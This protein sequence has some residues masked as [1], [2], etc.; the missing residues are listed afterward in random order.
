MSAGNLF[1]TI[2]NMILAGGLWT[3]LSIAVDRVVTV[4]N[5]SF[6]MFPVF[7][8]G[9]LGFSMMTVIWGVILAIIWLGLLVNYLMVENSQANKEV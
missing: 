7:Q 2:A 1:G 8:D 5:R 6:A 3:I 9:V 4:A